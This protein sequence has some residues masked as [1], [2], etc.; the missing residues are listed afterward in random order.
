MVFC[1]IISQVY[2]KPFTISLSRERYLYTDLF[3]IG[4]RKNGGEKNGWAYWQAFDMRLLTP[5]AK[6]VGDGDE[7]DA[8]H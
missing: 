4:R 2:S 6:K 7:G 3:I 8:S 1:A 5:V